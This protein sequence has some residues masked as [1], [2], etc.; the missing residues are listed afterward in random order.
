M[1]KIYGRCPR[2][3]SRIKINDAE[4]LDGRTITCRGCRYQIRIRA[5]KRALARTPKELV[6]AELVEEDDD[7]IE[8]IR[9]V[10]PDE[11]EADESEPEPADD[12]FGNVVEEEEAG[13]LPAYQPMIRPARRQRVERNLEAREAE[14]LDATADDAA[15]S[16]GKRGPLIY[17][18]AGTGGLLLVALFVAGIFLLRSGVGT[19]TKCEAPKNYV[20]FAP[21]NLALSATVPQDWKQTYAGGQM[22]IPISARFESGSISISIR[23]SIGGGALGQAAIAMQGAAPGVPK[24]AP[25]VGIHEYHRAHFEEDYRNYQEQ[26]AR[27]IKTRGYGEGRISDFTA[28]EGM[29]GSQISGCRATVMNS[30]HQF[31]ITCKCPPGQFKDVKPVFE[32]IINSL[33]TGG[34]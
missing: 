26:F 24:E 20:R 11:V 19:A 8:T 15:P 6:V 14:E 1:T 5:P 33:S 34:D 10:E 9:L 18:V 22:G 21:K 30:I 12:W 28:S 23:E 3:K 7:D 16:S 13:D 4:R 31:T 32:K 17:I 27:P 29:F 25:V 2:C